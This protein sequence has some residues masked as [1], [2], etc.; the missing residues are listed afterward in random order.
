MLYM[1]NVAEAVSIGSFDSFDDIS[2]ERWN[3]TKSQGLQ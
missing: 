2:M 1:H 3:P